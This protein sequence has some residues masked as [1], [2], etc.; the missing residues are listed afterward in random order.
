MMKKREIKQ[1]RREKVMVETKKDRGNDEESRA[2][3][4]FGVVWMRKSEKRKIPTMVI[5]FIIGGNFGI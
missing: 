5:L 3:R 1:R 2:C 4:E